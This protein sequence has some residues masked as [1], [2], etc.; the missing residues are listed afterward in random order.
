MLK[1]V[2]QVEDINYQTNLDLLK[3]M[4]STGNGIKANI[5]CVFSYF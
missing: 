1:E 3:E 5:K 4:K 2:F